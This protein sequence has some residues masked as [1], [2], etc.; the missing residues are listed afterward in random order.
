VETERMFWRRRDRISSSSTSR[1][2]VY[3]P[4]LD[5]ERAKKN[6]SWKRTV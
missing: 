2:L 3:E 5:Q 1:S 6:S 4:S